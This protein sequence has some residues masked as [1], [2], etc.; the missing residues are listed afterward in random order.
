MKTSM[1]LLLSV[2]LT[3]QL[4]QAQENNQLTDYSYHGKEMECSPKF[5]PV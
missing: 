2:L 5:V 4:V 1:T 3:C